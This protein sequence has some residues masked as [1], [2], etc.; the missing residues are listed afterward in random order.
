V[1]PPAAALDP[2]VVDPLVVDLPAVVDPVVDLGVVP[3]SRIPVRVRASA[4]LQ[5]I[6][7]AAGQF[8]R[9]QGRIEKIGSPLSMITSRTAS[10]HTGLGQST[11]VVKA[12]CIPNKTWAKMEI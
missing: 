7:P 9:R 2:L 10:D 8:P 11:V 3:S 12:T 4:R 1:A 5:P 6:A